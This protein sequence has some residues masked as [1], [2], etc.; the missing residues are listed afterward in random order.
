MCCF[1]QKI[2]SVTGTNIFAR[3]L[4]EGRQL[5]VYSMSIKADQDLAMILPLP[6]KQPAGEKDLEF[7]DLQGYPSFFSNLDAGFPAPPSAGPATDSANSTSGRSLEIHQV[8]NFEASFV[9]KVADFSR[10]DERFRLPDGTWKEVPEYE[11]YGFAVFKL[12]R[13]AMTVHPMAFSFAIN[14][15]RSLFFPTV[16]IHDGKV[17]ET[18]HFDHSLYCQPSAERRPKVTYW[19]ES[20]RHAKSFMNVGKTK[21]IILSDQHCYRTVAQGTLPNRDVVLAMDS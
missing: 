17:H 4:A 1:S 9:P 14:D 13:G 15:P 20:P 5:L 19:Q 21:G 7:I 10:L 11:N 6:A 8:G 18:A 2:I 12:K 3:P 16:H